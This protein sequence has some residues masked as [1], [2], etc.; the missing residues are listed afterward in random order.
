[1]MKMKKSMKDS[2]VIARNLVLFLA[3]QHSSKDI[4]FYFLDSTFF[5]ELNLFS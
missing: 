5:Q 1:M 2:N 3:I 4:K